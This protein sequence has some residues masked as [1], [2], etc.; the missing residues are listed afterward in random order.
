MPIDLY[1]P[2]AV[3][4]VQCM[5]FGLAQCTLSKAGVLWLLICHSA[6]RAVSSVNESG[7]DVS[8]PPYT[9]FVIAYTYLLTLCVCVRVCVCV[10]VG[11]VYPALLQYATT[12][13]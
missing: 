8:T 9:R 11:C 4:S 3:C 10:T 12:G 7:N 13:N 2:A 6:P 1:S 5:W